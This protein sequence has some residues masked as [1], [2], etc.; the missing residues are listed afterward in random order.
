L[1]RLAAAGATAH[2]VEPRGRVALR[3][4]ERGCSVSIC[5]AHEYLAGRPAGSVGGVV[6]SGVVDRVPLHGLLPLLGECRRG[7]VR[8]GPV[9][10][11]SG[12]PVDGAS[13][14]PEASD[15]LRGHS[16]HAET[17]AVLLERAGFVEVAPLP[18]GPGHD[19][20]LALS[21]AVPQ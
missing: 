10:I 17:W 16:L 20:R 21:A 14:G 3:A 8:G 5:E 12:P 18:A 13:T 1:Q 9:V 19:G 4:L 11:V 7:L 2:G 15:L 6:L